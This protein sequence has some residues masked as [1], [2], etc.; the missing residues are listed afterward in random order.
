MTDSTQFISGRTLG[1]Y[2]DVFK[3][4]IGASITLCAVAGMATTPG[5]S[6]PF[7]KFAVL[8]VAV[9]LSSAGAGAFNQYAERELDARMPRTRNRPFVTSVFRTGW[10]WLTG[11]GLIVALAVGGAAWVLNAHVALYVFLGAFVYGIVYTLW[12]KQRSVLNIV[13]GGLAGSFAVLAGAAAIA[14]D[15]APASIVLAVV[16][17][18]W[19]PPH[20]WSLATVYRDDYAVAGVPMLPVIVGDAAAAR[21][22]L[23]HTIVLVLM[24]LLPLAFG[25]GY[26]YLAGALAGGGLFVWRSIALAR[27]P[28]A[29]TA[30]SN[31]H[32]S[33]VQ[34]GVLL[35]AAIVDGYWN[36]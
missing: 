19:T 9:F 18:L 10:A 21:I 2:S 31:F 22:I 24:S 15:L 30:M 28:C 11:I 5:A 12:L 35:T 4:R 17:F 20:F 23:A 3:L 36:V 27:D 29:T 7:W 6:L 8:I 13:V 1:Q 25:M 16:L 26:I 34:L 32:A 14:P 33:L